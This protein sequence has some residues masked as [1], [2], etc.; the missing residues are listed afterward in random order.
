MSKIT[1]QKPEE[2]QHRY[3]A[4]NHPIVNATPQQIENYINTKVTNLA[5]AKET[6]IELAQIVSVLV[7]R[8]L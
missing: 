2:E 3:K 1:A 8:S 7:K 6:L 5:T 4:R